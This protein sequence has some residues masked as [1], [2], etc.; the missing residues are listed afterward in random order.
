MDTDHKP[1]R[2]RLVKGW[3]DLGC[4]QDMVVALSKQRWENWGPMGN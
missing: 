2:P 3:E 4:E 1:L